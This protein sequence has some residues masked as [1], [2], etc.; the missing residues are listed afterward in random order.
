MQRV[1]FRL[2]SKSK[3]MK[4]LTLLFIFKQ[5]YFSY[6]PEI[7]GFHIQSRVEVFFRIRVSIKQVRCMK[8]HGGLSCKFLPNQAARHHGLWFV[9]SNHPV[10]VVATLTRCR[11]RFLSAG[12]Y[13]V[14]TSFGYAIRSKIRWFSWFSALLEPS[15]KNSII[16]CVN[17]FVHGRQWYFCKDSNS[18][19]F[20][21]PNEDHIYPC[22]SLCQRSHWTGL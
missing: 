12:G 15:G 9:V 18:F 5:I 3:Q 11:L 8:C 13:Q 4:V 1:C 17:A 7:N 10:L 19:L 16:F 21:Y 20:N 22:C 14:Q 6:N 2:L